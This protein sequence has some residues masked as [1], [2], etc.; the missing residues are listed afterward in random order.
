MVIEDADRADADHV[1]DVDGL[2]I[3]GRVDFAITAAVAFQVVPGAVV[4]AHLRG[5]GKDVTGR[6]S[7]PA[8][9]ALIQ[10]CDRRPSQCVPLAARPLP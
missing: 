4:A 5:I 2:F 6:P 10:H 8:P 9:V 1:G 3:I 7:A